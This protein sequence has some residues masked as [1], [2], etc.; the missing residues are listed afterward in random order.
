MTLSNFIRL[1]V[2]KMKDLLQL[3][4]A[5]SVSALVLQGRKKKE[6]IIGSNMIVSI[7]L[8][9]VQI[10]Q[11]YIEK[12]VLLFQGFEHS[13]KESTGIGCISWAERKPIRCR[14]SN[15]LNII[16]PLYKYCLFVAM[17]IEHY[18][19]RENSIV[20]AKTLLPSCG[21]LNCKLNPENKGAWQEGH[22]HITTWLKGE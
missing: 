13:N 3:L 6:F 18:K 19:N 12:N 20:S 14:S 7:F 9:M 15:R 22:S 16:V 11:V 8:Q 17:G 5:E 21:L 2:G 1:V 4:G 10:L